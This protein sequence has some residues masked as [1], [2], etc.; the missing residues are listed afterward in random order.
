MISL[1]T[2]L[3]TSALSVTSPS[4]S[5]VKLPKI[6]MDLRDY[7]TKTLIDLEGVDF[8]IGAIV[9]VC[10]NLTD[11]TG[12]DTAYVLF[13]GVIKKIRK[14][15]S[16]STTLDSLAVKDQ[17]YIEIFDS[18]SEVDEREVEIA[19]RSRRK[20]G[21]PI[22]YDIKLIKRISDAVKIPV[23]ALGG[24]GQMEDFSNAVKQ[25]GASD[26][27]AGSLFVFIG[28]KRAVLIN[29]PERE[30]LEKIFMPCEV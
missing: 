3:L 27:A 10:Y 7:K 22:Y 17:Y 30:E 25:G 9:R 8:E 16:D 20:T 1:A 28:R 18:L 29:Y 5:L 15:V 19:T 26:V 23:I 12:A 2:L 4:D 14:V 11:S 24:A 6:Q 21:L 13:K